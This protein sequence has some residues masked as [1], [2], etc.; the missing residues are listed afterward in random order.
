[1]AVRGGG[2]RLCD[3]LRR[4]V[5]LRVDEVTHQGRDRARPRRD[6]S[7]RVE[8]R[9]LMVSGVIPCRATVGLIAASA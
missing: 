5:R 6:D 1:M 8:T 9:W 7:S 2:H 3:L 4:A